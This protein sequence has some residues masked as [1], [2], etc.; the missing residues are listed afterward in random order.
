MPGLYVSMAIAW[1]G[2]LQSFPS[3]YFLAFLINGLVYYSLIR[4][5]LLIARVRA[6]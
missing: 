2:L 4:L 3:I 5:V 1:F 6:Q